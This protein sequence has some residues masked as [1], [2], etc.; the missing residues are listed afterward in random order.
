ISTGRLGVS[1]WTPVA[2]G[3]DWRT[4]FGLGLGA[5]YREINTN[6]TVV[7]SNTSDIG[8]YGLIGVRWLK[9]VSDRGTLSVRAN[10]VATS[11][12]NFPLVING[13]AIP[14]GNLTLRTNSPELRIGYQIL[15]GK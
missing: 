3:D 13:G 7:G 9:Q 15:L 10:F 1:F 5:V 6:D 2:L 8:A 12:S 14:A 11:D 4:E